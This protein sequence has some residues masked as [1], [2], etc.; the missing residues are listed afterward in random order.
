M[1]N[2]FRKQCKNKSLNT[3]PTSI[4]NQSRVVTSQAM[5]VPEESIPEWLTGNPTALETLP[6]CP[7]AL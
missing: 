5:L 7:R 4:P 1:R 2:K 6:W 3:G